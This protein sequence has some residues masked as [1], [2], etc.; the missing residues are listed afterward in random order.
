MMTRG[1]YCNSFRSLRKNRL[2][3]FCH[4][5]SARG[6]QVCCHADRL[7]ARGNASCH[8]SS[9]PPRPDAMGRHNEDG[10][11]AMHWRTFARM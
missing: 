6:Y 5:G 10:D 4:V 9:R 2:A 3:A 1:T 11:A 7:L 8:K